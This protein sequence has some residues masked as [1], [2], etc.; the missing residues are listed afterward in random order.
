MW[1]ISPSSSKSDVIL[2][3]LKRDF[4]LRGLFL[5]LLL[6]SL[7]LHLHLVGQLTR[8]NH[9][10]FHPFYKQQLLD[11]CLISCQ[12]YSDPSTKITSN[13]FLGGLAIV[14]VGA[15]GKTIRSLRRIECTVYKRLY[16]KKSSR[17]NKMRTGNK[18][19]NSSR[20]KIIEVASSCCGFLYEL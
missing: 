18:T 19:K 15:D 4:P 2:L 7:D 5:A 17:P 9:C 10:H 16:R 14:T 20:I 1:N 6:P 8:T 12:T 11:L 13:I 3:D